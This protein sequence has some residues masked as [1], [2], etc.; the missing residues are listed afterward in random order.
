MIRG[1]VDVVST[2]HA[3]GW[4]YTDSK[5]DPLGVEAVLDHQVIG[6][7]VANLPRPDLA[8][9][10]LGDGKCGFELS[11]SKEVDPLYLPFVQIQLAGT[12]LS[13][14]RWVG[15][16]FA[17]YFTA[18]YERYPRAGRSG[19]VYGGLWTD[20]TDA[21]AML[22]GRVDIGAIMLRDAGNVAELIHEGIWIANRGKRRIQHVSDED[23]PS[24]VAKTLFDE[25][26]LRVLRHLLDDQPVAIKA[27]LV[28]GEEP[29][30]LQLS[31]L[32]DSISP[33]ECLGL[34]F[35]ASES[36]V[37][38]QIVRGGHRLPE[39][40]ANGM[41]RWLN[42]SVGGKLLSTTPNLPLDRYVVSDAGVAVISAGAFFRVVG[43]A[44]NAIRVLV[45]PARLCS[46]K[47][48][49][50]PPRGEVAHPSG[51]RVWV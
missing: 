45:L 11:F 12:D 4:L 36:P 30:F 19:S 25:E 46:L 24:L 15:A 23:V 9:A 1:S 5:K 20:R 16:G 6:K 22:K 7:A 47:Y 50:N 27:E 40:A 29:E 3:A 33:A 44:T 41:S 18:L 42:A 38:I 17:D 8:S 2:K 43:Q 13:L 35:L 31:T 49:K 28:R 10:G 26:L 51:A 14:R 32:E 48:H 21:A 39:F 34:I 37:T